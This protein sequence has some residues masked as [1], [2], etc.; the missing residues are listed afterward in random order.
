MENG[1]TSVT[2]AVT[3]LFSQAPLNVIPYRIHLYSQ[4]Y[5]KTNMNTYYSP[6]QDDEN[7]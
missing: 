3:H 7:K 2:G 6:Q 4:H 5:N 1:V